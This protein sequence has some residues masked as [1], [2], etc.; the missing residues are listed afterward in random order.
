VSDCSVANTL[1]DGIHITNQSRQITIRANR[2]AD[3]G[4]DAIAVVSYNKDHAACHD[5]L[6]A[7]NH[8]TRAGSRGLAVVGGQ[9]VSVS[10]NVV[11]GCRNAGLYAASEPAYDTL[12]CQDIRFSGNRLSRVNQL[13][14]SHMAQQ[15]I[16][17]SGRANYPVERVLV[18][19]NRVSGAGFRGL[20]ANEGVHDALIRGNQLADV[21]DAGIQVSGRDLVLLDNTVEGAGTYG[22]TATS[23]A[24]GTLVVAGNTFKALNR[25][26]VGYVDAL[27]VQATSLDLLVLANNRVEA[28]GTSFERALELK[29]GAG[30]LHVGGNRYDAGGETLDGRTGAKLDARVRVLSALPDASSWALGDLLVINGVDNQYGVWR[31]KQAGVLRPSAP[32]TSTTDFERLFKRRYPAAPINTPS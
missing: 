9:R 4:D 21:A 30:R 23:A 16:L 5:V 20:E 10:D 27:N 25:Q 6:V 11:D 22:L 7:N 3:T 18:E 28:A 32:Q 8:V 24:S 2:L 1:A 17:L 26:S 15:A 13:S 29:S 14:T 12:A 31:C 19:N